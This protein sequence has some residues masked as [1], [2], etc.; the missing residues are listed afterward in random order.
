MATQSPIP[1]PEAF[2][3]LDLADKRAYL[4]ALRAR[5]ED[6]LD[7]D[8]HAVEDAIF[9]EVERRRAGVADGSR[10]LLTRE[11]SIGPLRAKY[12]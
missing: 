7:A 2:D 10:R 8:D 1:I 12:G 5:I 3:Q 6:S 4:A 9:D 11:E